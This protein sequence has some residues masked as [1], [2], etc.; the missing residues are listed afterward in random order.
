[1]STRILDDLGPL[2][3]S[4]LDD[5]EQQLGVRL[6]ADYRAFMLQHNGGRPESDRFDISWQASQ[7]AAAAGKG[8]LLSWFFS[9]YEE[10]EENLLVANRVDFRGRLPSGTVAIGRDPGGNLLLLRTT[11]S[12]VGEVLYWLREMEAE[13]GTTPTED[14][15]GFVADSFDDFLANRLH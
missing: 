14:N 8:S 4:A 13:E 15:V 7:A 2:A 11:G 10:R 3:T 5:A 1:M 6:P 9:I 12:R